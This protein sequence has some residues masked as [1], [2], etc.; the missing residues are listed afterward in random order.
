MTVQIRTLEKLN[1]L[2]PTDYRGYIN[3]GSFAFTL[4]MEHLLPENRRIF[5]YQDGNTLY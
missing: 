2:C 5:V 1:S 3:C 4:Q